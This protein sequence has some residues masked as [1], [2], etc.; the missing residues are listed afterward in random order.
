MF[1]AVRQTSVLM[2]RDPSEI[3]TQRKKRSAVLVDARSVCGLASLG[4][5]PLVFLRCHFLLVIMRTL[6][7][8]YLA[9][10]IMCTSPDFCSRLSSC[11]RQ[12]G[13]SAT[14]LESTL[15]YQSSREQITRLEGT[16]NRLERSWSMRGRLA[17]SLLSLLCLSCF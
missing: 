6:D 2:G 17:V 4:P 11:D 1:R 12:G 3:G 16:L 10:L 15:R 5:L 14:V 9:P 13:L 8:R 7:N